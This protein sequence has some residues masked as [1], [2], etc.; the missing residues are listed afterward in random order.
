MQNQNQINLKLQY[1]IE[2][3][4]TTKIKEID[5]LIPSHITFMGLITF[6]IN[7]FNNEMSICVDEKTCI[8]CHFFKTGFYLDI[9]QPIPFHS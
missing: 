7:K 1:K 5:M 6:F 4:G 9:T 8:E 3:D 2:I